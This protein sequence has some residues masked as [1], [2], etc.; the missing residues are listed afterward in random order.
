MLQKL[1]EYIS[2]INSLLKLIGNR[3]NE[4]VDY[5]IEQSYLPAQITNANMNFYPT[6]NQNAEKGW[7]VEKWKSGKIVMKTFAYLRPNSITSNNYFSL[8]FPKGVLPSGAYNVFLQPDDNASVLNHYGAY[9]P[10]GNIKATVD[11]FTIMMNTKSIYTV[12][13]SVEVIWTPPA[14]AL[15][16]GGVLL[17]SIFKQIATLFSHKEVC[18]C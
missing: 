18:I 9:G 7:Y 3:L 1:K 14:S 17:K 8:S 16:R 10:S 4:E 15:V 2:K 12:R 11:Y 5:I 13:W 6:A